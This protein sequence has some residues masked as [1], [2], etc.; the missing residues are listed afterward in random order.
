MS[1][2]RLLIVED[3]EEVGQMLAL[4][5]GSRGFK[6]ALAEDGA[7]ALAEAREFLPS[8]LLL[9]VGLPDTDGYDLFKKFR[10]SARTRHIPAVALTADRVWSERERDRAREAGFDDY[11]EKPID[12]EAFHA[13]VDR[14]LASRHERP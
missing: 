12:E 7:S 6:V 8:L 5:F 11:V 4:F 14:F 13:L 9:D 1:E 10:E 2:A 3:N